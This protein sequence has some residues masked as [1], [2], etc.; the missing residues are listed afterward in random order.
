MDHKWLKFLLISN[1]HTDSHD[2]FISDEQLQWIDSQCESAR[3]NEHYVNLCMHVP[4]H[5]NRHPDRGWYVKPAN[6]QVKLYETIGQYQ[7]QIVAMLH[8]HF[9]NGIRGLKSQGGIHEICMPSILY[10]LDRNLEMQDAEGYNPLEF[11]PGYTIVTIENGLMTLAHKP[12][13]AEVVITK[14]CE[15][16]TFI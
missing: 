10:N 5:S 6:G 15:L 14:D 13:G 12:L 9:Y 8:G 7:E 2:G 1:A 11:R 4:T 16:E 3:T